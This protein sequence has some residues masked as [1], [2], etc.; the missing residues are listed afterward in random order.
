MTPAKLPR[1]ARL[2][3]ESTIQWLGTTILQADVKD[4][5]GMLASQFI[6]TWKDL[7]PETWRDGANLESIKVGT[8]S[9]R[10]QT[11][12]LTTQDSYTQVSSTNI[13]FSAADAAS[14]APTALQPV[15]NE[16]KL[17]RNWH[18]KLKRLMN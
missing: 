11:W 17:N 9:R 15:A 18:E 16:A 13:R 10:L 1:G 12:I 14:V 2:S 6:D 4:E 8:G 5:K 7:L 3:R